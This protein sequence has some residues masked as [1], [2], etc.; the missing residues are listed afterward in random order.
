[1]KTKSR[2]IFISKAALE[3][4]RDDQSYTLIETRLNKCNYGECDQ[5]ITITYEAEPRK[6][7]ISEQDVEDIIKSSYD[8]TLP[9]S[10]IRQKFK[11]LFD[12]KKPSLDENNDYWK[13]KS[14]PDS[15]AGN[16]R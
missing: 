4:L 13:T 9:V 2:D 11:D 3:Y 1:M 5:K 14:H 8:L 6:I 10:F 16:D 15:P 7:T 12:K